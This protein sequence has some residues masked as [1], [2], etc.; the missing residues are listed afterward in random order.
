MKTRFPLILK[1]LRKN[2]KMTQQQLADKLHISQ[3]AYAH[4]EKGEAEPNIETL[5]RLAELFNVS[6]DYLMGRYVNVFENNSNYTNI[7]ESFN[8][9]NI[10]QNI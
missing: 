10:R 1:E 6:L 2:N 4:Y 3:R 5:L 8:I 7:K 9:I